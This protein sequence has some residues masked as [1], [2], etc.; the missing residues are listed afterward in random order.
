MSTDDNGSIDAG[1]G[2]K[3]D[4][5]DGITTFYYAYCNT[6]GSKIGG[7]TGDRQVAANR[8]DAHNRSTRHSVTVIS[9]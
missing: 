9:E 8:A 7:G 3:L 6:E 4:E 1:A 2:E 5:A